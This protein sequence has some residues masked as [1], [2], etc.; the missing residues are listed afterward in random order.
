MQVI[1]AMEGPQLLDRC[2]VGLDKCNDLMPCPQ[3]DLYKPIRSAS[4]GLSQHHKYC[5][6]GI[7]LEG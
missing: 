6:F 7:V 2:V 5:R 1:E 4:Q 3:H